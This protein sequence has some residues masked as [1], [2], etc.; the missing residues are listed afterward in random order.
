MVVG[1]YCHEMKSVALS[2]CEAEVFAISQCIRFIGYLRRNL[3][4][5]NLVDLDSEF[6]VY[7]DSQSAIALVNNEASQSPSKHI[8]IRLSYI[9]DRVKNHRVRLEYVSTRDNIADIN[10]K[11]LSLDSYARH[12]S[13]MLKQV[14]LTGVKTGGVLN[15]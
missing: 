11:P 8:D 10:T 3:L 1:S 14:P 4:N 12:A 7:S 6:V 2:S 15:L 9:K 5:L 13:M